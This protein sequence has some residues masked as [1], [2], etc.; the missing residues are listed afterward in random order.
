[1]SEHLA[2]AVP[3]LFAEAVQDGFAR[4]MA[5]A[6]E[7]SEK[8]GGP[9]IDRFDAYENA[10]LFLTIAASQG[11][12]GKLFVEESA[13][14]MAI[15]AARAMP[16]ATSLNRP[17]AKDFA[18]SASTYFGALCL[19]AKLWQSMELSE[20]LSARVGG[21]VDASGAASGQSAWSKVRVFSQLEDT[22]DHEAAAAALEAFALEQSP[23]SRAPANRA[24]RS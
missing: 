6:L 21:M 7:A 8:A 13:K 18:Q 15:S 19:H 2:P 12:W 17:E 1:M 9:P 23:T 5:R 4:S 24:R 14:F 3:A 16:Y 10:C 22:V 20:G 11:E